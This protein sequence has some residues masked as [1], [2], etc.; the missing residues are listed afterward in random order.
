MASAALVTAGDCEGGLRHALAAER[1][2]EGTGDPVLRAA[3]RWSAAYVASNTGPLDVACQ[4]FDE[5]I[6]VAREHGDLPAIFG[7]EGILSLLL[8]IRASLEAETGSVSRA[9]AIADEALHVAR[10]RR[11]LESE[12]WAC[13]AVTTIEGI[14]GDVDRALP[15]CRRALEIAEQIGSAFSIAWA[16]D[17]LAGVLARARH[18]DSLDL[19]ERCVALARDNNTSLEGEASHLAALAEACIATGDPARGCA[20]AEEGLQVVQRRGTWRYGPQVGLAHARALRAAGARHAAAIRAALDQAERMAREV[21]APN[22]I[23]LVTLERAALAELEG[24]GR[25]R[26][27][28]LRQALQD[29]ERIG[30]AFRVSQI[31]RLLDEGS[32]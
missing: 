17:G 24:D 13:G 23:P 10:E 22:Y 3:A 18:P 5:L 16:L 7:G 30:A 31:R 12:G 27:T 1:L 15:R 6:A 25:A 14:D 2:V 21:V 4:R 19:A 20:V 29:F 8:Q 11:L 9:Y 26:L 28:L 32:R